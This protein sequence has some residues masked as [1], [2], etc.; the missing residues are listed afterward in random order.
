MVMRVGGR[1]FYFKFHFSSHFSYQGSSYMPNN[2]TCLI[3]RKV[4][5][6]F[7]SLLGLTK[8]ILLDC[9]RFQLV[10]KSGIPAL[11]MPDRCCFG[12]RRVE[13]LEQPK[14]LLHYLL[15]SLFRRYKFKSTIHLELVS[16]WLFLAAYRRL[17]IRC[18]KN[19]Q[20][21]FDN[22]T[23]IT[24]ANNEILRFLYLCKD[25]SCD[26]H[27]KEGVQWNFM[28]P[29]ALHFAG[30][31]E[32][33]IYS[34]THHFKHIMGDDFWHMQYLVGF[35]SGRNLSEFSSNL[36]H[37][38]WPQQFHNTYCCN[39]LRWRKYN[40]LTKSQH[41]SNCGESSCEIRK[42][43]E[44]STKFLVKMLERMNISSTSENLAE[45]KQHSVPQVWHSSFRLK[46]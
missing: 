44:D 9:V 45:N 13:I 28:S 24:S 32:S 16:V 34:A 15:V 19:Y 43:A 3:E 27:S 8:K 5:G 20:I 38:Q 31:W 26:N 25:E 40:N 42:N 23:I 14:Y 18:G 37:F 22:A 7:W 12:T 39:P 30:I 46:D 2:S 4:V 1:F 33:G 11:S 35:L 36:S 41:A 10:A 21:Y 29:N 6:S 17:M